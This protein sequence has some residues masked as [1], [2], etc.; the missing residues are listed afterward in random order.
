[1]L[2][3]IAALITARGPESKLSVSPFGQCKLYINVGNKSAIRV[4]LPIE[5]L[6]PLQGFRLR[7]LPLSPPI[8]SNPRIDWT[9]TNGHKIE[10]VGKLWDESEVSLPITIESIIAGTDIDFGTYPEVVYIGQS[11]R[12][13]ERLRE[14]K[15]L[16]QAVAELADDEEIRVTFIHFKIGI[17][18]VEP[19]GP[20]WKD[21]L[22]IDDKRSSEYQDKISLI[23]QILIS[24]FRPKYN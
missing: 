19:F 15:K 12:I 8:L 16:N 9:R 23:E 7:Q 3:L 11:F 1:M 10:I 21:I 5:A 24:F 2:G 13:L 20:V 17:A 14:H 4:D 18:G 22:E 6:L